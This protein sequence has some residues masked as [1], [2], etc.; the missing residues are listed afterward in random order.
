MHP[1]SRRKYREMLTHMQSRFGPDSPN[2]EHPLAQVG[3]CVTAFRR[4]YQRGALSDGLDPRDDLIRKRV[5]DRRRGIPGGEPIAWGPME[6]LVPPLTLR[7]RNIPGM[8]KRKFVCGYTGAFRFPSRALLPAADGRAF[9]HCRSRPARHGTLLIDC[10]GPMG[11]QVTHDR[12]MAVLARA[13]T[14]TIALYAGRP[15]DQSGTLLIA[16][17]NRVHVASEITDNWTHTGNVVDGPA[18]EWLARQRTPRVWVSDGAVTGLDVRAAANLHV[19]V[20]TLTTTAHIRRVE[21]LD[22]YLTE[23]GERNKDES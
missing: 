22:D 1:L 20:N 7:C 3:I 16:A 19:E 9:T 5:L 13:P 17:R 23:E 15:G 4:R 8:N 18:L 14:T 6:I 2:A 11:E 21:T 10:S 12:L